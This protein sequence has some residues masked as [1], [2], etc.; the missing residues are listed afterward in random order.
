MNPSIECC[1]TIFP[2]NSV[3]SNKNF[4][5]DS[6]IMHLKD[7]GMTLNANPE[8][9]NKY[10][11]ALA[12]MPHKNKSLSLFLISACSLKGAISGLR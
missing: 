2:F 9:I 11:M 7:L 3:S 10:I 8:N 1:S 6:N 4:L 5:T 12:K